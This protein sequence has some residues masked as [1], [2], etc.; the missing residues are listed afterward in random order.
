MNLCGVNLVK[1]VVTSNAKSPAACVIVYVQT[2]LR[3][4]RCY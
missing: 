3:P 1:A 4:A 2:P